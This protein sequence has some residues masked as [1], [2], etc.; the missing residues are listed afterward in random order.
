MKRRIFLMAGLA[1]FF[2][3]FLQQNTVQAQTGIVLR[4]SQSITINAPTPAD[5]EAALT[6]TR[7]VLARVGAESN[8]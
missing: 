3:R 8:A 6:A 1:P 2:L 4:H 7:N 5:L